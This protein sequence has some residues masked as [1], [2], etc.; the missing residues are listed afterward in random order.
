M[1]A[2]YTRLILRY[3]F[4][5]YFGALIVLMALVHQIGENVERWSRRDQSGHFHEVFDPQNRIQICT[6][7]H[8]RECTPMPI[9]LVYTWVNGTDDNLLRDIAAVKE[10]LAEEERALRE[11]LK[12]PLSR[13]ISAPMLVLDPALPAGITLHELPLQL[14]SLSDAKAL[15]RLDKPLQPSNAVSVVIFHSQADADKALT[16]EL[17]DDQKF[18]LSKCYLTTEKETPGAIPMN[19]LAYVTG[20]PGSFK[21]SEELRAKLPTAITDKMTALELYPEA[22]IALLYLKSPQHLTDLLHEAKND[23]TLDG[24]Q[25]A[26]SPVYLFWDFSQ[27]PSFQIKPGPKDVLTTNRFE[28]NGA[29]RHS[30]RSVEKYA[31]WVRHIFVVTNGQIPFWLNLENPRISVVTHQEIFLNP[32]DL[33]TFSS[34][35]IESNLHRIPGIAQKFIYLND[36]VMFGKDVWVDD[37]YT[38]SNGQKGCPGSLIENGKCNKECNNLACDWDG[39]DCKARNHRSVRSAGNAGDKRGS[40]VEASG[41]AASPLRRNLQEFVPSDEGFLSWEESKLF[42]ALLEEEERHQRALMYETNGAAFGRKLQNSFTESLRYVDRL[43]NRKFGVMSRKTIAHTP[44]MID[45]LVMQELQN[46]FPKEF[47]KTSG[48]RLRH[49]EDMQFA[50]S[51]FYFL[52]SVKQ[53]ANVSEVF[54]TADKDRSGVLSDPEIEAFAMRIHKQRLNPTDLKSLANDLITCSKNEVIQNLR[55]KHRQE[56]YIDQNMPQITKDLVLNCKPVTDRIRQAF[57]DQK[58]YKYQIMGEQEIHFRLITN[59]MASALR[60]FQEVRTQ[61]KKFICMNDDID[62]SK[63]NAKEVQMKM[64]EFYHAMFPQPSQFELPK[65]KINRF[66]YMDE[67]HK[68]QAYQ[69]RLRFYRYCVIVVLVI[70]TLRF[71]SKKIIHLKRQML[72]GGKVFQ[73]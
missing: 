61:P 40:E 44:H 54:D 14:P 23:L 69:D 2:T 53:K 58:K 15:L 12:C 72:H 35:A 64:A 11:T 56:V 48:H 42:N 29:L 45:K 37:F 3:K 41:A 13:C 18:L 51:Y 38:P 6:S 5:V 63:S 71:I 73:L 70:F 49:S 47:E 19:T 62:H 28:D 34:P 1:L 4:L 24:K 36:D 9:D 27:V 26:I 25:L 7:F 50:F 30:L 10:Q 65:E 55:T 17:S 43:Y 66:L 20:F 68:W 8:S 32:G 46:M 33:P 57:P 22:N 21:V 16:V 67:L 52:M 31:P 39:G 59:N 60:H